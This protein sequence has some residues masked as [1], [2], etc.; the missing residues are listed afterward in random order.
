MLGIERID[1]GNRALEDQ[2]LVRR[3]AE[4]GLALTVCPL[5]NLSLCVVDD[6]ATHPLK[7]MLDAGLKP[8]V[9]A[10]DPAYF[11]GYFGDNLER[12]AAALEL[13]DAEILTL[14]RNSLEASFAP[15]GWKT[16]A[17]ADFDRNAAGQAGSDTV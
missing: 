1:H 13:S 5:S 10:D 9:N 3:I 8:T 2:A 6:L 4:E 16:A 17:L 12:V 14:L 11:G 15:D 7:R